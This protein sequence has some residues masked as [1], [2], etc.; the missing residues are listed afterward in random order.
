MVDPG[1]SRV[2]ATILLMCASL[3]S[4]QTKP[5]APP[6]SSSA[7]SAAA[8]A[9]SDPSKEPVIFER[10]VTKVVY[11]ADGTRTE[12]TTV[13][14]RIQ[15]QAGVQHFAVLTFAYPSSNGTIEF[16]Y[17]R[18]KKP[19]GTVIVTPNSNIQDMPAQVA[20]Q[21]PM[22]S[23]IH[24]KHVPVKALGV[25]DTL[26]YAVR[27]RTLKPEVP[28]QFWYHYDFYKDLICKDEELE[29]NVPRDKYV[30]VAS[31]DY[32]PLIK[33]EGMR[34]V[35]SW[36][37]VNLD[38][39][40]RDKF[41][42]RRAVPTP[43]VQVTTFRSWDEVGAWYGGLQRSQVTVTPQIQAKAAELTKGLTSDDEK[44][45]AL[46]DFVST[47]YHYVALSFGIGRYQP[48]PA[49]EVL[50]NEYG[51]CKD[52]HTLLAA[53]LKAAGYAAWPALINASRKV[54][55]DVPSPGQFN[56]V[57]T[58]VPRDATLL[59]MDTTPGVSPFGLLLANLRDKDAL[60]IR[61]DKSASLGKAASLTRTP[62]QP[63]FSCFRNFGLDGALDAEGTLTSK[64]HVTER[65]DDEVIS[66]L[67][68]RDTPQAHWK[69]LGQATA[70]FWGFAG[71]VSDV[72]VSGLE[73]TAKPFEL[74]YQYT[75]KRLGDWDKHRI[76]APLAPFGLESTATEEKEPQE[77]VFLGV[78]EELAYLAR[79]TLPAQYAPKYSDK[80]DAV[81]EFAEY[82]ATYS[83]DNGV[84]TATRR[85]VIKKSEISVAS[86]NTYKQF[87]KIVADDRDRYI[88]LDNVSPSP[89]R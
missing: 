43:S 75:R 63:P 51:D 8:L 36:K 73:D 85:L 54:D 31:P 62:P 68:F 56:H 82:H 38:L 61:S 83:I 30:K 28:G 13:T 81:E 2:L 72:S 84:L 41:I 67:A 69:D 1:R 26:E 78:V 87:C 45:R 71:E 88:D 86:W 39:K 29:I 58:V 11:E 22:Y 74:S 77:P 7:K 37:V 19:D 70:H 89:N 60:V 3:A 46:Y 33:E 57:I 12:E 48:H 44:I 42:Q 24:E 55:P 23:D 17:V 9:N 34:R 59:W 16:D 14:M 50:E 64:V 27:D 10:E 66:R 35:Y 53:L 32:P 15:S 25:G 80:M 5:T 6:S 47:H 65:G 79:I 20:L 40:N 76:H 52:K 21:A 49:E 4:S 18:V